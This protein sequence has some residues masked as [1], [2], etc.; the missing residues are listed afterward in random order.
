MTSAV[1]RACD[2]PLVVEFFV[3]VSM[4][5]KIVAVEVLVLP[6]QGVL[7]IC[8]VSTSSPGL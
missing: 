5:N 6:G 1:M 8:H 4:I 2:Y 7:S 3:I